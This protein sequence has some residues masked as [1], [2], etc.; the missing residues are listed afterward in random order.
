MSK[1]TLGAKIY[2]TIGIVL[3]LFLVISFYSTYSFKAVINDMSETLNSYSE[4]RIEAEKIKTMLLTARRHEKD[5]LARKDQKY[6]D[7]MDETIK[8]MHDDLSLIDGYADKAG[9]PEVKAIGAKIDD[10]VND[11]QAGFATVVD[12]I[13]KRGDMDSGI[14]GATRKHSHDL[15]T[16]LEKI[17]SPE[18]TVL[19]LTMRRHEK[20]FNLRDDPEYLKK[21]N[22]VYDDFEKAVAEKIMDRNQADALMASANAYLKSFEDLVG[23]VAEV[24]N[25]YPVMQ[26]AAHDV[27]ENAVAMN[28]FILKEVETQKKAMQENISR[29][30]TILISVSGLALLVGIVFSYLSVRSI[31]REVKRIV[32]DLTGVAD[33][34]KSASELV[35]SSSQS[36]AE[37]TSENAAAIEETTSSLDEMSSMTRQNADNA[38]Q[39]DSIMSET[40]EVVARA[41][42]SM[43]QMTQSMEQISASG[44]EIGK[45]IKTID[46]IAFQTNLLALNAAVEA[47]RAG[48]AGQGFA[49]VADEVRNL[50]QRAAEAAKNTSGLIEDTVTK[51]AQGNN[52]VHST[53][54]AFVEVSTGASKVA[55]LVGEIAQAS[56]EQAQGIDQINQ[57]MAQMD[58]IMQSNAANAE[59]TAASSEELNAQTENMKEIVIDLAALVTKNQNDQR[60]NAPTVQTSRKLISHEGKAS[61]AVKAKPRKRLS[62]AEQAIPLDEEFS[63]F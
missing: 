59:E 3:T 25:Q 42:E 60:R 51:I 9:L 24:L 49:V 10:G 2:L 63:D 35:S 47:A 41:G 28:T 12:L 57:A 32:G 33:E 14:Q 4:I 39:A 8:T 13:N 56:R 18:L 52:I 17:N 48:E 27:E 40:R 34:V 5:F 36:I 50:A 38:S 61:G 6:L 31:V 45:I 19:Y 1:L 26:K 23:N 62:E 11:Y 43:K 7:Q 53:S 16:L 58:G 30:V 20:D 55:E 22:Q 29:T 54:E 44:Q 46:E 37:G 21:M 15:E